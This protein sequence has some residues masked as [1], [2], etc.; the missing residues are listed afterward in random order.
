[1]TSTDISAELFALRAELRLRMGLQNLTLVAAVIV[2]TLLASLAASR[3]APAWHCAV[4]HGVAS[5]ALLLQWCHH[6]VR[7]KQI[8][9]FILRREAGE[10]DTWER[11]LPANR[12]PGL[13][14]S[15]WFVST[16]GVFLGL[17]AAMGLLALSEATALP[18]V[19]ALLWALL[20]GLS[21]W[22]LIFNPKEGV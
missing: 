5:L 10:T 21:A 4:L 2:F 19:A 12:Q 15:R 3:G 9:A 6:G 22:L 11:W 16:K 17:Q 20:F 7:T 1:M 18:A 13:L 14:G 8:K